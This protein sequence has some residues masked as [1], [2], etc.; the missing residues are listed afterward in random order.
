[1]IVPLAGPDIPIRR[2]AACSTTAQAQVHALSMA[3]VEACAL[4]HDVPVEDVLLIAINL[5]GIS[6]TQPRNRA[7]LTLRL[8]A[9]PQRAWMVIVPLNQSASPFQL[10]D[11]ELVLDGVA[12][13]EVDRIDADDAVGGYFRRGGRALTLNPNARSRCVGCAFCPNTLEAA[14]DPRM[15]RQQALGELLA[16]LRVQHPRGDLSEVEE[17]TVSTGCFEREE[18]AL[19]HLVALR[20]A[21]AEAGVEARI[22]FLSSV[23][24][25]SAAFEQL[26]EQVSPFVLR[27]TAECFTRR[28]VMLKSTKADLTAGQMPGLLARAHRAGLDTS[29][30]HIVGLDPLADMNAGVAALAPHISAFPN[31]QV[32]QAHNPLMAQLRVDGAD[33]LDFYLDARARIEQIMAPLGLRPAGWECYRPLWYS[34]FAGQELGDDAA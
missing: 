7:R 5:L 4:A 10:H 1:V 14:A 28:D 22:G 13:A 34:T 25:S 26:A 15:G 6:S 9:A 30:T 11:R 12:L 23:L 3:H 17:V 24:R 32:F 21:L 19:A 29:Y 20:A 27:L 31:F 18:A 16:A 33:T 8:A 2:G